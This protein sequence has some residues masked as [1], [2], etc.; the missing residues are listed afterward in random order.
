MYGPTLGTYGLTCGA[1]RT[2][3]HSPEAATIGDFE[4]I[5][6]SRRSHRWTSHEA[7]DRGAPSAQ[8]GH[9]PHQPVWPLPDL[10]TSSTTPFDPLEIKSL[11]NTIYHVMELQT[12]MDSRCY[13]R[14]CSCLKPNEPSD[15][16]PLRFPSSESLFPTGDGFTPQEVAIP[17][18]L[19][20]MSKEEQIECHEFMEQI[21]ERYV[22]FC[23]E[24]QRLGRKRRNL[25]DMIARTERKIRRLESDVHHWERRGFDSIARI[26]GC[27]RE[28]IR[29]LKKHWDIYQRSLE[30]DERE[31]GS[32]PDEVHSAYPPPS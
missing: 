7:R 23:S 20:S 21:T 3:P 16:N 6:P 5:G 31:N 32:S 29:F 8:T 9:D 12:M 30:P 17:C 13:H 27:L 24:R 22:F 26:P 19:S 2:H 1:Y 15:P 28:H 25:E 18:F 14:G 11:G 4:L 10:Y